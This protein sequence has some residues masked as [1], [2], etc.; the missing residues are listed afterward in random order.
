MTSST[1]ISTK[2][3]SVRGISVVVPYYDKKSLFKKTF[4][5]L[6]I[7]LTPD[8]EVIVVDDHSPSG[9]GVC[10]C[11]ALTIVRPPKLETHIYR[12]NTLR[13]LGIMTAKNDAV[14]IL[15]PDCIPNKHFLD[16]ARK[17]FDPSVLFA[18]RIDYLDKD[19]GI[20]KLD[21]RRVDGS[22]RWVDKSIHSAGMVWGGIMLFSKSRAE[23]VGLFDTDYDSGW[24][25]EDHDFGERC[26]SS[27]MRLRYEPALQV[28]HQWHPK[29]HPNQ[30]RNL[31]LWKTKKANYVPHL[32]LVTPYKPAVAVLV[33]TLRRP[34]YI[35]Q[36]MRG[37]FRTRVPL[38]VRLV[39]QGDSTSEQLDALKWWRGRWAVD[40]VDYPEPRR[41]SVVRTEAMHLF[42]DEGYKYMMTL[43]DDILPH[44]GS[45]EALLRALKANPQYHAIA[46]GVLQKGKTRM[47]GGYI[48]PTE[49]KQ[50]YSL[51][52]VRGVAEVRFI[53]SGFTAFRLDPLVPYDT[54]YEFGWNDFD[55]SQ[56]IKLRGLRMAVCGD[57]LAYHRYLVTSRGIISQTDAFEYLKFRANRQRH[58]ASADRFKSKW[59]FR[60][61]APKIWGGPVLEGTLW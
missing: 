40:V 61:R 14:A 57:A 6:K 42:G 54:E 27:G 31:D 5:E 56:E 24:G 19:G 59:G 38:K 4:N 33:A 23:L 48:I 17:L 46:G 60:P 39:N 25:A 3:L 55:W 58:N 36:V 20:L 45:I 8:D 13:N 7:Q 37:I 43:D 41:L 10:S 22:S 26:Y 21:P 44:P 49:E 15:D 1:V 29:V 32:N 34:H 30:Q 53:S 9:V 12:L 28:Q 2:P 18:G 16:N 47:L 50:H 11:Q 51:P 35:D 52:L